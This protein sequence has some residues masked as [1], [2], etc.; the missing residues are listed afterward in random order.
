M[1]VPPA[2]LYLKPTFEKE[3]ESK[4]AP[5]RIK[6]ILK[7]IFGNDEIPAHVKF[8]EWCIEHDKQYFLRISSENA[9]LPPLPG[10]KEPNE[11]RYTIYEITDKEYEY[12]EKIK[13]KTPASMWT[14]G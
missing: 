10:E 4:N 11:I 13:Y 8:C 14:G 3:Y 5:K 9:Y 12:E 1:R 6:E 7:N 2:R